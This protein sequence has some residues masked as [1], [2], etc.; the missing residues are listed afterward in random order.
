MAAID[1]E[2]VDKTYEG[3]TRA[4]ADVSL[5]IADGELVVLVGPSGC[6]KS[7]V[8][9]IVAGLET[10]TGGVV[11]IG[12]RDATGLAAQQRN[13]AMVFQD[14]ALYPHMTAREN[15]DF[16][17]RM[18]KVARD[19]RD[20]QV[21][22]VAETLGLTALLDRLP[23]QLSGGERQRVAMGRALVREPTVFL[24]DEPLSNLDAKLRVHVRAE[25]FF[26]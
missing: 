26:D 19:A 18:R 13:V 23:K 4:L 6:G 24:L 8:L 10:P 9:R 20:A 22:R 25:R 3:G 5:A 12:G 16:P 17:L 15:L 11:R 21:G 14:Y 1:L 2:H 7:T